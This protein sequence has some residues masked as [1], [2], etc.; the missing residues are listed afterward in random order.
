MDLSLTASDLRLRGT[1]RDLV[2]RMLGPLCGLTQRVSFMSRGRRDPRL[3][4]AGAE[5]TGVHLLQKREKPP[6]TAYHI[7]GGGVFMDEALIRSLGESVERYSQ[8]VSEVAL[9]KA[10][11]V[12]THDEMAAGGRRILPPGAYR[13]FSDAQH[14]DAQ[15]PFD[16]FDPGLKMSWVECRQLTGDQ[17]PIWVPAQL[18][19]VG[20][21]PKR[22]SGEPWLNAALTTGTAAHTD[23]ARALRSAMLELIQIDAAMGHWYS[24]AVAQRIRLDARTRALER[25][26]ARQFRGSDAV[27]AFY[28]L[29]SADLPGFIVACVIRSPESLPAIGVGLGCDLALG[30]AL[31]KALI[32]A[33]SVRA[34]A[35]I[36]LLYQARK[37][38]AEAFTD[39]D[40]N[41][42]HYARPENGGPI[43]EKFGE[44]DPVAASDL[45]GDD[46]DPPVRQN[47]RLVQGFEAAGKTLLMLDLSTADVRALGFRSFR[48]WSPDVVSLCV[49]GFPPRAHPRFADYGG[50][51]HARPHPYA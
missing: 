16:R 4:T 28:L 51:R 9:G 5:L 38:A 32:E 29:P 21:G 3:L 17:A 26:I 47:A 11:V 20:Y 13:F 7:G 42:A 50:A 10:L 1:T 46:R 33:A 37:D 31:Y 19:L 14:D 43:E 15:L 8:L 6:L 36:N 30:Q 12:A 48:V 40:S 39:F 34:L 2:P 27:P 25:L 18:V 45:P 35:R 41:V 49:P 44:A 22:A 24:D 23:P